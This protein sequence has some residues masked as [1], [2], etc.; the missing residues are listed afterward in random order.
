LKN[1]EKDRAHKE[2]YEARLMLELYIEK[3]KDA[4]SIES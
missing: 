3:V 1:A 4:I 2:K